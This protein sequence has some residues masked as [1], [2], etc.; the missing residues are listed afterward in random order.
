MLIILASQKHIKVGGIKKFTKQDLQ[1]YIVHKMEVQLTII[2]LFFFFMK[3]ERTFT[4][5]YHSKC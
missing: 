2:I 3:Q 4:T 5:L 1:E